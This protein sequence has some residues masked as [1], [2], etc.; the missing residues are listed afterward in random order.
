ME[1]YQ[2]KGKKCIKLLILFITSLLCLSPSL[3]ANAL[4]K[5]TTGFRN[6]S[7]FNWRY[8]QSGGSS[9]SQTAPAYSNYLI[10]NISLNAD[11]NTVSYINQPELVTSQSI[12]LRKNTLYHHTIIFF[13]EVDRPETTFVSALCPRPNNHIID[14]CEVKEL[15]RENYVQSITQYPDPNNV[16]QFIA[17]IGANANNIQMVEI[18]G[19][20]LTDNDLTSLTYYQPWLYFIQNTSSTLSSPVKLNI[21][22]SPIEIYV[23]E[24]SATEQ[25]QAQELEDRDNLESQSTSTDNAASNSGQAAT[26]T[27]TT[28][29]GAFTQFVSALS[30]VSGSSCV[31]P[32]MQVYSLDL[33]QMDLCTYDIPPQIMALV[34]IGM[35]FIIVPLGIH[36]VKKMLSLYKEITG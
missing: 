29:F 19:H 12:P 15:S 31:L 35:V 22:F 33:G 32:N 24:E 28:L 11:P 6:L 9:V 26:N 7:T 17:G 30:N 5:Y 25:E 14:K 23:E 16:G 21:Y 10:R 1:I 20:G 36:L 3:N 4:K 13:S 8:T 2:M 18:W 34:S 27:G